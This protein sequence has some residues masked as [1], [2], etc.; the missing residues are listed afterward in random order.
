MTRGELGFDIGRHRLSLPS[1]G[2]QT[3]FTR[4]NVNLDATVEN[5]TTYG[6]NP[7]TDRDVNEIVH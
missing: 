4:R 5:D 7:M 6:K 2:G 1:Q 3:L